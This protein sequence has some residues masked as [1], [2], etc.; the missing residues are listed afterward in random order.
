MLASY[1]HIAERARPLWLHFVLLLAYS[2]GVVHGNA[3]AAIILGGGGVFYALTCLAQQKLLSPP[4]LPMLA[5]LAFLAV[6]ALAA[7]A[8]PVPVRSWHMNGQML[9]IWSGCLLFLAARTAPLPALRW[10]WLAIVFVV[11]LTFL[12]ADMLLELPVLHAWRGANAAAFDYNRGLSYAVLLFWPLV[13]R[14]ARHSRI[15]PWLLGLLLLVAACISL[16]AASRLALIMGAFVYGLAIFGAHSTERFLKSAIVAGGGIVALALLFYPIGIP[17]LFAHFPEAVRA[18]P[19][20]WQHRFE[21]WD[22]A[23][24]LVHANPMGYGAGSFSALPI[25]ATLLPHFIYATFPAAHPHSLLM[26]LWIETGAM[27]IMTACAV[28][29]VGTIALRQQPCPLR[30]A[31]LTAAL[32]LLLTAYNLWTDSLWACLALLVFLLPQSSGREHFT[33]ENL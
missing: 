16:S 10:D 11:A 27:G 23:A 8:S 32:M 9:L 29:A 22:Y 13:P 3:M 1:S 20:S 21:I 2:Y 12:S 15:A 19:A 26:Q 33:K 17:W 6:M 24:A 5:A 14:L 28:I 25:P 31:A 18:L 4:R 7:L 30:L